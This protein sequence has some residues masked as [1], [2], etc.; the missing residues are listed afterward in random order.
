MVFRGV[1]EREWTGDL[2][3][4]EESFRAFVHGSS[5]LVAV[6]DTEGTV[7][8]VSPSVER[9][10]GHKPEEVVGKNL[11][12]FIHPEDHPAAKDL[13]WTAHNPGA[14]G[15]P[16]PLVRLRHRDGSWRHIETSASNLLDDSGVRRLVFRGRDV[17]EKVRLEGELRASEERFRALAENALD[18]VVVQKADNTI[19]YVSPSIKRLLGYAPEEAVGT[20]GADHIHP[21]DLEW[22]WPVFFQQLKTPGINEGVTIRY[23]HK[24]GSWRWFESACNNQIDNP[25]VEGLVFNC[26]DVTAR[27]EAEEALK[28]SEERYRALT[29][30]AADLTVV[31]RSDTTL[32]YVSPSIER[33]LGYLP[34]EWVDARAP[35]FI[36]PE[37]LPMAWEAFGEVVE[38]P[39]AVRSRTLRYRHK[40]GSWRSLETVCDN[41]LGNPSV[42]GLI[43]NCR[44]VTD[45]VRAEEE[46][47]RLNHD[48]EERV[49]RRTAKLEKVLSEVAASEKKLYESEQQFRATFEQAAVGIAHVGLDGRWLRVNEK[50]CDIVRYPREE[51]VEKTFHDVTHP[52]DLDADL[53]QVERMLRGEAEDFSMEKRYVRRDGSEVWVDLTV[54]LVRENEP[55]GSGPGKPK[56][57]ISVVEDV[58]E[59]RE[60]E[61]RLRRALDVLLALHEA[62]HVIGSTLNPD[63]VGPEILEIMRRVSHLSAAVI[64]VRDEAR[65]WHAWHTI[66]PENLCQTLRRIPEAIA[67]RWMALQTGEPRTFLLHGSGPEAEPS[68]GLC[69]PLRM[70]D[71]VVGV[72]E[73]YGPGNLVEKETVQ[74]LSS[75]T[76][77]AASAL[78]NARLYGELTERESR[79]QDLVGSM[80]GTQE[81][82][83]RRIAYEVHDGLAQV[84][85]AAYQ[86][87]QAYGARHLPEDEKARK[88]LDRIT[89]LVEHTVDEARR[90]IANL[91][92]TELDDL[93]LAAAMRLQVEK[94]RQNGWMVDYE[95][96]LGE[97]R[98]PITVEIALYRVAQE[99]L[100]NFRKH[101]GT[102]RVR[103][104][105]VRR[106]DV[107]FLE[108]RDEGRGFD[109]D[110]LGRSG[111]GER[112]GL[113]G[114]RERVNALGGEVEI[115]SRPGLGTTVGVE[116][117]LPVTFVENGDHRGR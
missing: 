96:T 4:G 60:A 109:P 86:H 51:L 90:I 64:H 48:L 5:D 56:Y 100:T 45:R 33:I 16:G 106:G 11:L 67:A 70:R 17:T 24:D 49:A 72:L 29:E 71:R 2:S 37:D 63:E 91:R 32:S 40:D 53:A 41:Q 47:R 58:T 59:R 57:F 52:E 113:S 46:V 35:E 55:S 61:G 103:L 54:S 101:A 27:V 22:A 110:R 15:L 31:Q 98:L 108:V 62:G 77:Q 36:H 79:L 12:Q 30:H 25:A 107:V 69:L 116:V 97:R 89:G 80:I 93:G 6:T 3:G 68:A 87:L 95:E 9:M 28:K 42:E 88:D 43:F 26:R 75:L 21:E 81:E 13:A 76:S 19:S 92:P 74:I 20:V 23:R 50:L 44:D 83:R 105:V 38:T 78:E 112:V 1:G 34:E 7:G 39:G 65:R 8:Y 66:G 14:V 82:E 18:F 84:A 102:D 111:P 115:R 73:A 85:A 117:P 99:A 10:Y 94:L 104:E 114:M